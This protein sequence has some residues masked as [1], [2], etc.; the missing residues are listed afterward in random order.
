MAFSGNKT[1]IP[2]KT[3]CSG[4]NVVNTSGPFACCRVA[5]LPQ[6]L[7]LL[8]QRQAGCLHVVSE[9]MQQLLLEFYICRGGHRER[10][11]ASGV[12]VC[13]VYATTS[14]ERVQLC[15][16]NLLCLKLIAML[17]TLTINSESCAP[18]QVVK[19]NGMSL[20]HRVAN[21]QF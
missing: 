13:I 3:P 17:R 7:H 18:E 1:T 15:A 12:S 10:S 21:L 2:H 5:N 6:P 19:G 8:I 9:P 14:C 4:E 16:P 11:A 20:K